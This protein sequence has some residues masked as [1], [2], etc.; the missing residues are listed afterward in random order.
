MNQET[1]DDLMRRDSVEAMSQAN[2][3][4]RCAAA[5]HR[6]EEL[7]QKYAGINGWTA[8]DWNEMDI[9]HAKN[10]PMYERMEADG[11]S[12]WHLWSED[13]KP[14]KHEAVCT[15]KISYVNGKETEEA[16]HVMVCALPKG[17]E[18]IIKGKAVIR[19]T[20]AEKEAAPEAKK[21]RYGFRYGVSYFLAAFLVLSWAS[22]FT[23]GGLPLP[24]TLRMASK[25]SLVYKASCEKGLRPARSRR[26]FTVAEGMF[27]TF[28]I[29]LTVIPSIL[30]IIG[31]FINFIRN[32][33][34]K[35]LLLNICKV[36]TKKT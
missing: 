33:N 30:P 29:S 15:I 9:N 3:F 35:R 17:S 28:A 26:F 22:G 27:K 8:E 23:L 31:I 19:F 25:S 12:S 34:R 5:G 10:R 32:V 7:R 11:T 1:F 16:R 20:W 13:G 18:E 36:K 2:E 21:A 6:R 4:E 24:G 14:G